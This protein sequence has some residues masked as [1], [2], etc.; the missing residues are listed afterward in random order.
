MGIAILSLLNE[1]DCS[2]DPADADC[3]GRAG[4]TH[5]VLK[6]S[7]SFGLVYYDQLAMAVYPNYPT[8][9]PITGT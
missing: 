3:S 7:R 6:Q 4:L 5:G 8:K 9:L 2:F 1:F